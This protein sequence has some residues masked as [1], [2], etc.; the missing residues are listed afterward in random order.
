[1]FL[2]NKYIQLAY[3]FLSFLSASS[4][5]NAITDIA[6]APLATSSNSIVLPN[7]MYIMDN[8][9][10]MGWDYMPDYVDDTQKC[11][12]SN[13]TFSKD[14]NRG[15]PPY[16]ASYFNKIYYNP[17]V[18]YSPAVNANGSVMPEM[19]SANTNAWLNV[20][21]DP[22]RNTNT[23]RLIPNSTNTQGYQDTVWCTVGSPSNADLNNPTVCQQ[24][25]QYSFP[26]ATFDEPENYYT[27]PYYYNVNPFEYCTDNTL[28]SC[29][30]TQDATHTVPASLLWCDSTARTNCQAKYTPTFRYAKWLGVVTSS[31]GKIVILDTNSNTPTASPTPLYVTDI[32]VAG[33]SIIAPP[34]TSLQITDNTIAAQRAT[35]ASNIASAINAHVSAPNYSA[36]VSGDEVTISGATGTATINVFTTTA[37][38]TSGTLVNAQGSLRIRAISRRG[39]RRVNSITVGGTNILGGTVFAT[40]SNASARRALAQAIVNQINSYVSSPDYTAT[41]DGASRPTITINAVTGG[42]AS[43]GNIG[44][45][46]ERITV[47]RVVN[48]AGG[49]TLPGT[50]YQIPTQI[51]N[52]TS[53]SPTVTTFERVN[54][55]PGRTSYPKYEARSDCLGSTCTYQEE[56]T[57]FAN[58]YAY[59]R[60]RVLTMKTA[61]SIAFKDIGNNFRI[62]FTTINNGSSNYI[63]VSQFDSAQKADWY[64]ELF[65]TNPSG[66][67][68]LRYALSLTGRM[69]AGNN[70]YAS[71]DPVQYSCQQNFTLL[72]TDGFWNG[73]NNPITLQGGSVGNQDNDAS[74]R[75]QGFYEGNTRTSN[76]LA[77]AAKY[78]YET[79]L[80][81]S[82]LGNCQGAL[83]SGRDVCVDNVF[84]TNTDNNPKQHMTTFTLG[85]GVDGLLDYQSDYK[86]ANSGDFYDIKNNTKDWSVP[87]RNTPTSIDDLWHAAVNGRGTYFS[88]QDPL[89]LSQDLRQALKEIES[90]RGAGAA[91]AT[92]TLNP[93]AGDNFAFVA[94]YETVKWKGNLEARQIDLVTGDV[95]IKAEWCLE[96]VGAGTC[97]GANSAIVNENVNG[98]IVTYCK[99]GSTT[100]AS[101]APPAIFDA[102]TGDCR[103]EL[104]T[105]CQG[106][107]SQTVADTT[108]TRSILM[109]NGNALVD[110]NY[111]NL[112]TIGENNNLE[113]AF[114]QSNLSQWSTLTTTQQSNVSATNMV[115]FLRGQKGYE[116][117]ASNASD[118]Q[119]FRVREAV[120]GDA[121]D[122][123]PTFNG[124]PKARYVDPGYGDA[125]TPGSFANQ[126][127]SRDG[128]IYFGTNDGMLHAIDAETGAERWAFVPTQVIKNMWRLADF[129]Y[130]TN[131]KNFVNG[132]ISINDICT[133]NCSLSSATWKTLLVGAL[134]GGG[135]GFYA[136]DITDP[137][138]PQMMWEFDDNIDEDVGYSFGNPVITKRLDGKWVVVV[139]SGYNNVNGSNVFNQGKGFLYV[140]DAVTGEI[141]RDPA[142]NVLL[143]IS[144]GEGTAALPSGLTKIRGYVEDARKNNTALHIYG[145]DLY[146]NLWRF[147]INRPQTTGNATT[148]ANPFKLAKFQDASSNNQPITVIP[149]LGLVDG[150][151][152]VYLGT[153]RYLGT[154]DLSDTSTQSVYALS[155]TSY[156]DTNNLATTLF[157]RVGSSMVQQV[158]TNTGTTRTVSN[159][160][161]DFTTDRGWYIDLPDTGERQNVASQLVFGTL[162]VPTIVPNSTDCSPGGYGWVNFFNF[163][164]GGII[165]AA[166][167]GSRTNA[168]VVGVNVL[169]INGQPKVSVVTADDPTPKSP[170][171]QP[172]FIGGLTSGFRDRRVIWRELVNE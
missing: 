43:N 56:M 169:Y 59:Y 36:S 38:A 65:D 20:R 147:D 14:C 30:A 110:F 130:N 103:V 107:M 150:K 73:S 90:K 27:Y 118:Q 98:Q 171:I 42:S 39:T 50:P 13:A 146:G 165:A 86:T 47:D 133:A 162:I 4:I 16:A 132:D 116:A 131:H 24:N 54:I 160:P 94:S 75:S 77:D 161:V 148:P 74:E 78:Y 62:G 15:D 139:T 166:T 31:N 81:T 8:S 79:D 7:L 163:K 97:T 102:S 51:T 3:V 46:V 83:G 89:Q 144:T 134:N 100:A 157:P 137:N 126:Q 80:R 19:N 114:L 167:I 87:V 145:G 63:P 69:Y 124:I 111:T 6:D 149:E 143:K 48:V 67:T 25:S 128:T 138:N 61:T 125:T 153:G 76:S 168:P 101:C 35:L 112:V 40:G 41:T 11:L 154:T 12:A 129:N 37:P 108:D 5:A 95:K 57:N 119:V 71:D 22:F 172:E 68:P 9:G 72:T 113:P 122:S 60:I 155:D 26:S 135:K 105:F 152:V 117:D 127:A 34:G 84:T 66:G 104:P 55:E 170:A 28:S 44:G 18:R 49:A 158:I 123:T 115:N 142:T 156:A 109:A 58:W 136:L 32:T 17:E 164:T 151:R 21:T 140:L 120:I 121:L 141:L 1:M 29:Q 93:V 52:F 106:S 64:S 23:A 92:S 99:T 10:S 45:S 91:A 85:L 70:P 53:G 2:K 82:A 96:D 159:N 88:A 33:T